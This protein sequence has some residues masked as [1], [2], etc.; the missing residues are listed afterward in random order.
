MMQKALAGSSATSLR[1]GD[2]KFSA[3]TLKNPTLSRAR[4]VVEKQLYAANDRYCRISAHDART[5][6]VPEGALWSE[7]H[8]LRLTRFDFDTGDFLEFE[9]GL[10]QRELPRARGGWMK[11][12]SGTAAKWV[13]ALGRGPGSRAQRG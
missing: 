12:L 3:P 11:A 9:D 10:G 1:G 6:R 4:R 7:F 2:P 5:S 13:E 8:K